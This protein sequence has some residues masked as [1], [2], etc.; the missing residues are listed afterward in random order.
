MV[1]VNAFCKLVHY[2]NIGWGFIIVLLLVK[3]SRI[4]ICFEVSYLRA[5]ASLFSPGTVFPPIPVWR[6]ASHSLSFLVS[7]LLIEVIP[8][9]PT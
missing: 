7:P 2:T 4:R 5:F 1:E 6:I 8:A 3:A 9:D